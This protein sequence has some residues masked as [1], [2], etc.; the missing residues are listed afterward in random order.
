MGKSPTQPEHIAQDTKKHILDTARQLFSDFSYL[1]V[2]MND[3][4]K[5]LNITKAALYYHFKGKEEIYNNVLNDVMD[6]LKLVIEDAL[7][8]TT[9]E[10]KLQKFIKNYLDFG[11]NEKNFIKATLLNLSTTDSYVMECLHTS[12]QAVTDMVLPLVKELTAHKNLTEKVDCDLLTSLL[13]GTMNFLLLDYSLTRK[14]Y[15]SSK[16]ANQLS[17]IIFHL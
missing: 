10:K 13:M 8:E 11:A 5:K 9:V 6:D 14:K 1:G 17:T 4:A 16:I 7:N 15:D 3:I 2:S 12:K